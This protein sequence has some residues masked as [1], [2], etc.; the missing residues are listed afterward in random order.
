M[1]PFARERPFQSG[2][3]SKL[4]ERLSSIFTAV[5]TR[6]ILCQRR[7]TRR[8]LHARIGAA[9][10]RLQYRL[11]DRCNDVHLRKETRFFLLT[12]F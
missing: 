9:A 7:T 8:T 11:K 4:F 6:K 2:I 10:Y 3:A 12:I 5:G 1:N